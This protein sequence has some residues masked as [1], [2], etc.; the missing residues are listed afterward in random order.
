MIDRKLLKLKFKKDR[1]PP[2]INGFQKL[3]IQPCKWQ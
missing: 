3:Y 1:K 2:L